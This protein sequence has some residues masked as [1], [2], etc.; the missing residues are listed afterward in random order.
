MTHNTNAELQRKCRRLIYWKVDGPV[1]AS[2][3]QPQAGDVDGVSSGGGAL[4]E[5]TGDNLIIAIYNDLT[6]PLRY[7]CI[8]EFYNPIPASK[9]VRID[10]TKAA[11]C[12]AAVDNHRVA[13]QAERDFVF[14]K[15]IILFGSEQLTTEALRHTLKIQEMHTRDDSGRV[16][17]HDGI[18][19]AQTDLDALCKTS[20]DCCEQLLTTRDEAVTFK[21]IG[22]D[23]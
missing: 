22:G 13:K 5:L 3:N 15:G 20:E 21:P 2:G 4:E 6:A 10:L 16:S 19:Q 17:D 14:E 18:V 7:G 1:D 23:A 8:E 12:C 11:A 9:P